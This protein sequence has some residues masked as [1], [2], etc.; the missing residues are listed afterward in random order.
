MLQIKK[1]KEFTLI[2]LLVVI[3]I[4]AILASMLLPALN[5]AREKAHT[6]SCASNLKQLGTALMMYEDMFKVTPYIYNSDMEL[7]SGPARGRFVSWYGLLYDAKLISG[8][9]DEY[10]GAHSDIT[11]ILRCESA[12]KE[13]QS[14]ATKPKH[15]GFNS[16]LA[17]YLDKTRTTNALR[18]TYSFKTSRIRRPSGRAYVTDALTFYTLGPQPENYARI[19]HNQEKAFNILHVDGHVK[20]YK[21]VELASGLIWG[22]LYGTKE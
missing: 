19:I 3:A 2:E 22:P 4:I 6:I 21:A 8:S 14:E 10:Y 20:T 9:D 7:P 1:V 17:Y 15:Y 11:P 16:R 18:N 5:Q 13:T 12:V